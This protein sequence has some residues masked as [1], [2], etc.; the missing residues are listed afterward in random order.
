M[1]FSEF[2][3]HLNSLS[4]ALDAVGAKDSAAAVQ[5]ISDGL[6]PFNKRDV[7][8]LESLEFV[9]PSNSG[10]RPQIR[11]FIY[12]LNSFDDFISRTTKPSARA[13]FN[14][15]RIFVNDRHEMTIRSF[16][17]ALHDAFSPDRPRAGEGES[18]VAAYVDALTDA[19]HDEA[20]FP[21]LFGQLSNDERLSKD[22]I[23]E[24]A[25]RFAFK[26]A[27]STSK[28]TALEKIWKI[29]NASETFAAK[30]RAMKGKSAA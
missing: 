28:K 16:L 8:E 13:A 6:S 10:E 15:L 11:E 1:K 14:A 18:L 22:D 19:K 24:I 20:R 3:K 23:V 26:M 17:G 5:L 29:H 25:S 4:S 9:D 27:K 2:R 12:V 21:K 7:S 30:S